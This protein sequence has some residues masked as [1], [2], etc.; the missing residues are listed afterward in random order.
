MPHPFK[1]RVTGNTADDSTVEDFMQIDSGIDPPPLAGKEPAHPIEAA[2]HPLVIG[3]AG[4]MIGGG[5]LIVLPGWVTFI[6]TDVVR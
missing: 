1:D 4:M 3:D 5:M 2:R 6:A